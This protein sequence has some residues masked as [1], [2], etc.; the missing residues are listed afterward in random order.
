MKKLIA[1]DQDD[2]IN[3]TKLPLDEEMA[4]LFVEL[5]E[6]FQVC[7][8]SG[9]NWEVMKK[10][11]ID[12]L[13][14]YKNVNYKNYLIMPTTG[15]QLW[16][17]V[18]DDAEL[19]EDQVLQDGF[20]REYAYF[21]T[22]S[23]VERIHNS[24]EKAAKELGYWC[25]NPK[26]EI[27][28]NRGSQVTFSALGQWATPE[29]KHAWDPEMT[30]RKAIVAKIQPVLD[31]LDL[32]VG[33]GGATSIDVT[34]PG[35]DKAYGMKRLM[36]HTGLVKEDILFIGDKLQPGGNDYP[37]KSLSI[38]TIEVKSAEDTKWILR[39]ILGIA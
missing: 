33:I 10:N 8:I 2:T 32:Q 37:V 18:G 28:E 25:E 13:K 30:K 17:Y 16:H 31:E 20:K 7:I 36:D 26:G 39:G 21:L 5:L 38:D 19:K 3:I 6:K 11:D 9:T 24:I 35:I 22:D 34:L 23:Q 27:I 4:S 29:E 14:V 15:T 12:T 1:F